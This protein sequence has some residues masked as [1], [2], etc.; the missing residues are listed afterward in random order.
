MIALD[1]RTLILLSHSAYLTLSSNPAFFNSSSFYPF[2]IF[3]IF[4]ISFPFA[5][6]RRGSKYRSPEQRKGTKLDFTHFFFPLPSPP[7][8][9]LSPPP[10]T[11]SSILTQAPPQYQIF[12]TG[13]HYYSP[14]KGGREMIY[15]AADL[16]TTFSNSTTSRPSCV[17][18]P[19]T[20]PLARRRTCCV[21]LG[22]GEAA[23]D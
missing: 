23:L 7:P 8:H 3:P 14:R 1:A 12:C 18:I 20:L 16:I 15:S 17:F 6:S 22:G 2:S 21:L 5:K 13:L 9:I 11:F 10:D 4:L 19:P